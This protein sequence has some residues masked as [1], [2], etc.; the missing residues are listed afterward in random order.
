MGDLH[1]EVR[2]RVPV[3]AAGQ[4]RSVVHAKVP[5]EPEVPAVPTR[6]HPA[7]TGEDPLMQRARALQGDGPPPTIKTLKRELRIGQAKAQEIRRVLD[8]QVQPVPAEGD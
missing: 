6:P 3:L 7:P 2:T 8:T 1:P 4:G 5:L